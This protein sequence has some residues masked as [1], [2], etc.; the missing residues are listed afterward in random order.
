MKLASTCLFEM[1]NVDNFHRCSL[2]TGMFPTNIL[3]I[4]YTYQE[5]THVAVVVVIVLGQFCEVL[6][7]GLP[8]SLIKSSSRSS[9]YSAKVKVR[10]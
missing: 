5:L 3:L 7:V 8:D 4:A 9:L 2:I 10:V 1:T 6:R